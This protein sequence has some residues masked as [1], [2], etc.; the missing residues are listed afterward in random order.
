MD[1]R[2]SQHQPGGRTR[3]HK[4]ASVE[5]HIRFPRNEPKIPRRPRSRRLARNHPLTMAHAPAPVK[6]VSRLRP[7]RS[8]LP[9][10]CRSQD[11][12]VGCVLSTHANMHSHAAT[13]RS[14]SAQLSCS[15][16][17]GSISSWQ[18]SANA[19][20]TPNGGSTAPVETPGD[21]I[22]TT[23][24]AATV[25]RIS[26]GKSTRIP[27]ASSPASEAPRLLA[28]VLTVPVESR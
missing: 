2:G 8:L 22:I 9:T 10:F 17:S 27:Q 24:V 7:Q 1:G 20:N 25:L 16:I 26:S 12:D 6:R 18:N 11:G 28:T 15:P 5:C 3:S 21:T 4:L 13:I 23:S 14:N 19:L